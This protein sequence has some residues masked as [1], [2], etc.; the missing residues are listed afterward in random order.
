[1]PMPR[2]ALY[3]PPRL[4]PAP[5]IPSGLTSVHLIVKNQLCSKGDKGQPQTSDGGRGGGGRKERASPTWQCRAL[6]PP[7]PPPADKPNTSIPAQR[8]PDTIMSPH[9]G[10]YPGNQNP[11]NLQRLGRRSGGGGKGFPCRV[12][13][14]RTGPLEG[15][16]AKQ[17]PA[18]ATQKRNCPGH[19][20]G[21]LKQGPHLKRKV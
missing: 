3:L 17:E 14:R 8:L 13:M 6:P 2:R 7:P 4:C 21:N 15:L 10:H 5:A 11:W 9:L 19:R 12:P 16:L 1:M 20:K 18:A